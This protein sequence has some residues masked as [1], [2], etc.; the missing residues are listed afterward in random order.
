MSDSIGQN[1]T[2]DRLS[3]ADGAL[4]SSHI[5]ALARSSLPMAQGL[6]A[7][8]AEL[9]RGGLRRSIEDLATTL[10]AGMPLDQAVKMHDDSLPPHLPGL[11][12][13]GMRSGEL[14]SLLDRF[15][16]Y[17]SI[18]VDLKR[19][20]WLSLAYPAITAAAALTLLAA[21]ST[22]LV[23]QFEAIYNDFGIP[24][25]TITRVLIALSRA[26]SIM[27]VPIGIMAGVILCALGP[28]S[29]YLAAL[30]PQHRVP[31]AAAGCCVADVAGRVL[32]FA[33]PATGR[34]ASAFRST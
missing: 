15:Y 34:A 3:G 25:P 5:A 4:L 6:A 27:I 23:G 22:F 12:A 18:G 28:R 8:A 26:V 24:L 29:D 14:G 30:A 1:R 20:L 2:N 10:E 11:L 16:Q 9:P 32:S 33:G 17:L 21:V 13:A 19:R 31:A 7:L